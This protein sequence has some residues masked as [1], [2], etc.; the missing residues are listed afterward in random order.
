MKTLPLNALRAFALVVHHGGVRAAARELGVSHSAISR[1]LTELERWLGVPVTERGEGQRGLTV[2]GQGEKLAAATWQAL[3]DITREAD[4]VREMRSPYAVTISTSPSFAAR[5]LLPR[6]PLLERAYPRY[7]VSLVIDQRL[8]DPHAMPCDFAIRMGSG[9]WSD[10]VAQPLMSDE[11]YPVMS[12]SFWEASGRPRKLEQ[13]SDLRLLHDRDATAS[14]QLWRQAF[15]PA[16]L[17]VRSGPR[18]SSSDLVLR[19]A[20]QGMGVALARDRLVR[21]D[22][23]SGALVRPLGDLS[24]K[25]DA[26]YW[27]ITP[28]QI[29]VRDAARVVIAWLRREAGMPG[30][31]L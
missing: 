21:D 13:L 8:D 14:W 12:P 23:V 22:L 1:H 11:L 25:I 16:E 26:A 7:E 5:W 15:G 18:F 2:T 10:V 9:P 20:S 3:S 19:A 29:A 4:A 31:S 6:L 17:N 30:G 24:I 27:L 28:K